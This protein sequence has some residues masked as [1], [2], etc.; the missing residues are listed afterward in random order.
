MSIE[1]ELSNNDILEN[2]ISASGNSNFHVV[3]DIYDNSNNK[4]LANGYKITPKIRERLFDRIL[5][6]PIETSIQS[7]NSVTSNDLASQALEITKSTPILMELES[8]IEVEA[9][10][11]RYLNLDPLA[12][13]LL[14]V[15]RDTKP[16]DFNHL[17][18]VTLLGRA[19]GRELKLD[20]YDMSNLS[21]ACILH[22]IGQLYASI[23]PDEKLTEV[24]WRKIMVHPI[25]GGSVVRMYMNYPN[26]VSIAIQEHHE[27]CNGNGYPKHIDAN[28]CSTIGQILILAEAIAG[29]LKS[30]VD[31]QNAHIVLKLSTGD[32]PDIPLDAFNNIIISKDYIRTDPN[33]N[34]TQDTL[35][36]LFQMFNEIL[37]KIGEIIKNNHDF[38]II[39]IAKHLESRILKLRQSLYASGITH[40]LEDVNWQGS[41]NDQSIRA[42]LEITTKEIGWQLQDIVRDTALRQIDLN[43]EDI[44]TFIEIT[45]QLTKEAEKI[46]NQLA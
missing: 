46:S 38:K 4:L 24:D 26:E 36:N 35:K 21:L 1:A 7:E 18:F 29:I 44:S 15:I 13:L 42:E 33:A 27:R 34:F 25:I 11:L 6:K 2:I 10:E 45:E 43:L 28:K 20:E 23:P 17:I 5:R 22:D 41:L 3:E 9:K 12:S 32:Y 30:G 8:N 31:S 40:Y 16:K 37:L 14:S 19:I 39:D